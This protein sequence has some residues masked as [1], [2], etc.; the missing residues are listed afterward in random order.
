MY[1]GAAITVKGV[2][3]FATSP[4]L[5]A[6]SDVFG[7]KYIFLATI[8][9]TA[10]PNCAIGMGA[11]L[12]AHLVLVGLSGLLA[13][14]FPIAFAYISDNGAPAATPRLRPTHILRCARAA[15]GSTELSGAPVRLQCR[16]RAA[17]PP[18]ASPSAWEWV[19]PS[20]LAPR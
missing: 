7:R 4:A 18:S 14:T 10:M 6:L 12:E 9:G 13:A 19:A 16:R 11:S 15:A 1:A 3:S 5:G 17:A 8:L 20:W 2:L